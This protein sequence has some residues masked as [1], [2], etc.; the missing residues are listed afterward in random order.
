MS[1]LLADVRY[2]FRSLRKAPLFFAIAIASIGFGIGANT[3]VFTLVDQV[4]VRQLPVTR[5]A[6]LVQVSAPRTESY[7]GT[8]GDGTELSYAMYRDIRDRNQV[9][10]G[11]AC[12]MAQ[13]INL[14][15]G[16]RSELINGELVSGN[17][18]SLLGLN[19]ALGRLIDPQ[20]DRLGDARAVAV[21]SYAY[22]KA[23]FAGDPAVIGR[24][25]RINGYSYQV[26]GVLDPRF[27]GL[28]I[29]QPAQ[30][31][32]PMT[33]QPRLG[34]GWL[35]LE[36]RRFR[37]VQVYARLKPGVHAAQAQA[38]LQPLYH[39]VLEQEAADPAFAKASAD[40]KRQFLAGTLTVSDASRGHSSLRDSVTTPLLIL[41]A[42]AA[43][44]LLIVCAN[45]ANL[46]IA[47]GAARHRELALRLAVGAS[48][49]EIVRLLLV[50]SLLLALAGAAVG[51]LLSVWGANALLG[52]FA[53]PDTPLPISAD[54]DGRILAFTS[55]LAVLTAMLAGAMPAFRSASVDLAP[56]LKSSGGAVVSEQPRLRKTLVVAQVALSFLLLIGA[57]LFVRSLRNLMSVDTGF[58][59]SHVMTFAVDTSRAAYDVERSHTFV[60]ALAQRLSH[61]PGVTATA[62]TFMPLLQGA[63]WG[64][65]FTVEGYQPPPGQSAG[66]AC[67]AV[68]PGFFKAMGVPLLAGREFTERDDRV[69]PAPEGWPYRH[70]IVNETF[71]KRYFKGVS[72]IG[73]HVGI[74]ADPGTAMP[75][76]V[77]GVVKDTRYAGIREEQ[78]PQIFFAYLEAGQIEQMV[79]Y[80]RTEAD[81]DATAQALRREVAA[82]D[83]QMPIFNMATLESRVE[84]SVVNERL[85]ATL[86]TAL[87]GMATLLSVI[88]LYGVMTYMVTRRTR[89]IGIRMALGA[90]DWQI[91]RSVLQEAGVLVAIGLVTGFAS[92]WWLGRYVESQLYGITPADGTTIV[93]AAI[94]LTLVA[95]LA[96]TL[97]ARR[98]ARVSPMT[99]LRE[100]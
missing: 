98:A 59:T 46:L 10:A 70:A 99:A 1:R 54:P 28:D 4:I 40:V 44:V 75:I 36:G 26:I 64:M 84:R 25:L 20:D 73:R 17:F 14:S 3:T 68:A 35:Q 27:S 39:A 29:G 34:P 37:F 76:E 11:T 57:G 62:F 24:M 33:M 16:T 80:V 47:R 48:R 61:A 30:A 8:M 74:G 45:V 43:A 97:P 85:I 7:G 52:F 94:I 79:V 49:L 32:L 87:S 50:E 18:F 58:R 66:S 81:P 19:P 53:S 21:L 22:W 77:V 5:P 93:L 42:I 13:P 15:D 92:A 69:L 90:L 86:S 72:P 88:G 95:A 38:S 78:R 55:V 51:V 83:A 96:A 31:Y 67:N 41:M 12:R 91:A 6:E 82:L 2:A 63:E 60:K 65:D 100:E 89:E 71:A 9:F 56:T 23:R